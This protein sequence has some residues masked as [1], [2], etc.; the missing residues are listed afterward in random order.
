[1]TRRNV[2]QLLRPWRVPIS[3]SQWRRKACQS[4]LRIVT[5]EDS[6]R[7][8]NHQRKMARAIVINESF[9]SMSIHPWL[10]TFP[11]TI[12]QRIAWPM[13]PPWR[14]TM[15][16]SK[17]KKQY[18]CSRRCV[19]SWRLINKDRS[20]SSSKE[21]NIDDLH[22]FV[23]AISII[24]IQLTVLNNRTF[25]QLDMLFHLSIEGCRH[26]SHLINRKAKFLVAIYLSDL[27]LIIYCGA[28]EGYASGYCSVA[29]KLYH[30]WYSNK[31]SRSSTSPL[32]AQ[33]FIYLFI[34][35]TR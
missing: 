30:H 1:M 4:S 2:S 22:L 20:Q 17:T 29:S 14:E 8:D 33:L 10:T 24:L 18:C 9:R 25:Q 26:P 7:K 16:R 28:C 31:L 6:D 34:A 12:D 11:R 15:K 13:H 35:L 23:A 3:P 32:T 21:R 27:Y 5:T 19:A